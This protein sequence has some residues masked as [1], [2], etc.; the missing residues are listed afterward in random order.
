MCSM[1]YLDADVGQRTEADV[2]AL[3]VWAIN[4]VPDNTDR[5]KESIPVVLAKN[6][7]LSLAT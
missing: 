1:V 6:G 7:L 2:A 4:V 3:V 5:H